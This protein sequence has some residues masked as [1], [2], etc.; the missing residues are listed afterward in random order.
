MAKKKPINM[1]DLKK[2]L[3]KNLTPTWEGVDTNMF[4]NLETKGAINTEINLLSKTLHILAQ[5]PVDQAKRII[6]YCYGY[7]QA[8]EEKPENNKLYEKFL[9]HTKG[10]K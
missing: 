4:E 2:E 8:K 9:K 3:E 6:E 5:L 1:E 10:W 7:I